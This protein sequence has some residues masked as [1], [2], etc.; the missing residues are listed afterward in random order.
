M[1][2]LKLLVISSLALWSTSGL[3][4]ASTNVPVLVTKPNKAPGINFALPVEYEVYDYWIELTPYFNTNDDKQFTFEGK[5]RMRV[6]P[7]ETL[8]SITLHASGLKIS[9]DQITVTNTAT[10]QHIHIGGV[11]YPGNDLVTLN[12]DS[13]VQK[14]NYYLIEFGQYSGIIRD[15]MDGFYRSSY[16]QNGTTK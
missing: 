11:V 2:L 5:S 16:K 3:T 8:S 15:D 4:Y 14:E 13:P 1:V 12:F 10:D 9:E 6:L 7:L